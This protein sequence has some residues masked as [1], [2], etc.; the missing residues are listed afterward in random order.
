MLYCGHIYCDICNE[1]KYDFK[2]INPNKS[3]MEQEIESNVCHIC[4]I[5]TKYI[6]NPKFKI[7][8]TECTEI[9]QGIMISCCGHSMCKECYD[10]HSRSPTS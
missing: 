1:N 6:F 4:K 2:D 9:K 5:N 3:C 7:K 10:K 8:C